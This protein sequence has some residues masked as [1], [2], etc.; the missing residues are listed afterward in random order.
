ME[1]GILLGGNSRSENSRYSKIFSSKIWVRHTS[2]CF[3]LSSPKWQAFRKWLSAGTTIVDPKGG[4]PLPHHHPGKKQPDT[5][6][7]YN[8][9][10]EFCL[11]LHQVTMKMVQKG[12]APGNFLFTGPGA[13]GISCQVPPTT[14]TLRSVGRARM[15]IPGWGIPV[16]V[17]PGQGTP[18]KEDCLGLPGPA[19]PQESSPLPSTQPAPPCPPTP[20][21]RSNKG[22]WASVGV[23]MG[24]RA[25]GGTSMQIICI[26]HN[27]YRS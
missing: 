2:K 10:P 7:I 5:L 16:G 20:A 25:V 18:P 23:S 24:Y 21:S 4:G 17:V 27:F 1:V 19:P 6:H 13:T 26:S 14:G 8:R 22:L 11:S 3:R 9:S 12:K 15:E